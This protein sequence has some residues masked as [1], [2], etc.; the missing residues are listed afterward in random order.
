MILVSL[1]AAS[2]DFVIEI[3]LRIYNSLYAVAP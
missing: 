3:N 2:S 1:I